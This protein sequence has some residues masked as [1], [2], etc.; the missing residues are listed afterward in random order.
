MKQTTLLYKRDFLWDIWCLT[1]VVGIWPRYI[2]P[3]LLSITEDK[4][5]IQNLPQDLVGLKILLIGDVHINPKSS[6]CFFKRAIK[7]IKQI[8][9][10]LIL[11]SGDLICYSRL[12][13]RP[14][15][16][17]F[18]HS[19]TAKY[20]CYGVLGNHDY[21]SYES[22]YK[23]T[24]NILDTLSPIWSK[25]LH[26]F[27]LSEPDEKLH[28]PDSP[29]PQHS[30]LLSVIDNSPMKLLHNECLQIPIGKSFLNLTGLGD[31]G[32]G[33]FSP[34]LAFKNYQDEF[35][36]I[37]LCHNPDALDHGLENFPGELIFSGH[38][39]GSQVYLPFFGI[40]LNSV[41]NQLYQR[42]WIQKNQK[43]MFITRGLSSHWKFR[44]CS[45][46]EI[47][48][49]TLTPLSLNKNES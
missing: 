17:T 42:G 45:K 31:L 39:H 41:E 44:W 28:I 2:E 16:E 1:S 40:V 20:G 37:T 38:T 11:F 49:F 18:L 15:L 27:L 46:P 26:D 35:P 3:N 34:E 12:N 14:L 5:E 19:L 24:R 13:N 8:A 6:T 4:I 25:V 47:A 22:S 48:C 36:G 7:K 30:S 43:R 29:I 32:S 23:R 33:H 10:D 21:S 9:P